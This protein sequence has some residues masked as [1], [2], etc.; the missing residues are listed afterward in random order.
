M[1]EELNFSPDELKT[2]KKM[3]Y[4]DIIGDL[5]KDRLSIEPRNKIDID[6][7]LFLLTYLSTENLVK[8]SKHLTWLTIGLFLTALGMI[9]LAIA[10]LLV[11]MK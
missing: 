5:K 7:G 6:R 4:G 3:V 10:Q 9:G 8:H 2:I 1:S 11:L